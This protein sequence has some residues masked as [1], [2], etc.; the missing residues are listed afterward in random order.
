MTES[1]FDLSTLF[2]PPGD[3][4]RWMVVRRSEVALRVD[5]GP[6]QHFP[7]TT[8]LTHVERLERGHHI[9]RHEARHYYAL[10]ADDEFALPDGFEW[11]ALRAL[12]APL[13]DSL[14]YAAGRAV[15]LVEW[16]RTHRFCGRCGA[17]TAPVPGE[18]AM[19]CA[20]CGLQQYPRVAPAVI[21]IVH[22]GDEMLLAQGARFPMKIFSALAGFVEPGESLEEAVRREVRE[23]VGVVVGA[24]DYFDSQSWPFPNSLMIGFYAA[25]ES[26]DL[27]LD[28]TEIVE[29]G[30]FRSYNLPSMPGPPSIARKL[31]DNFL[32]NGPR[33]P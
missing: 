13:G 22:R 12:H 18:R 5:G 15:Q 29:A 28:P 33:R 25:Y 3:D 23:E 14:W 32:E 9:G 16:E 7:T 11:V 20:A 19:G 24:V 2:E 30:W 6:G 4:A 31:I 21:M 17:P 26:G 27:V 10:D 1:T 8:E